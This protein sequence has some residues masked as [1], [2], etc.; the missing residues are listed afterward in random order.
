MTER[1]S[2]TPSTRRQSKRNRMSGKQLVG[3]LALGFLMLVLLFTHVGLYAKASENGYERSQ[4]SAEL[5]RIR[6]ENQSLRAELERL[7]SPQRLSAVARQE[8]M[9]VADSYERIVLLP[10]VRMAKADR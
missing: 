7:R 9:V 6:S 5:K 2:F 8:G 3:A 10:S 4:L 1:R